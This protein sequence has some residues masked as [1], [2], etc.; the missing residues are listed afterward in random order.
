VVDALALL[1]NLPHY[2]GT[3][4]RVI[5]S[6]LRNVVGEYVVMGLVN[7]AIGHS[8][9]VMA[10]GQDFHIGVALVPNL[11]YGR[12]NLFLVV[13]IASEVVRREA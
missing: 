4:R 10:Y 11:L 8:W 6:R 7:V 5:A 9:T 3:L 2:F 13:D 1:G 12:N